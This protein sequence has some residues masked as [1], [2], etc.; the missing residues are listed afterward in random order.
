MIKKKRRKCYC[1][2]AREAHLMPWRLQNG[3]LLSSAGEDR[4]DIEAGW[5]H[6]SFALEYAAKRRKLSLGRSSSR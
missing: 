2:F 4:D 1:G 6:V 3:T 5:L